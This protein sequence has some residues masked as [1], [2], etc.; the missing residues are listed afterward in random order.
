MFGPSSSKS[1]LLTTG[2]ETG[3]GPSFIDEGADASASLSTSLNPHAFVLQHFAQATGRADQDHVLVDP[4]NTTGGVH[5]GTST[6]ATA[7]T[8]SLPSLASRNLLRRQVYAA[9]DDCTAQQ[10][11]DIYEANRAEDV[12]ALSSTNDDPAPQPKDEAERSQMQAQWFQKQLQCESYAGGNK[13]RMSTSTTSYDLERRTWLQTLVFMFL[14]FY[15]FIRF[16]FVFFPALAVGMV[17]AALVGISCRVLVN[18]VLRHVFKISEH[19]MPNVKFLAP[20]LGEALASAIGCE[21]VVEGLEHLAE[22]RG[23]N[24]PSTTT[25]TAKQ[26]IA[27]FSHASGVDPFVVMQVLAPHCVFLWTFKAEL[28]FLPGPFFMAYGVSCEAGVMNRGNRAQAIKT[29]SRLAASPLPPMCAPEGTR[30]KSG[31]ILP[32]LKKGMFHVRTERQADILP[33]Y[34]NGNFE[35]WPP[36]SIVPTFGRVVVQVLPVLSV[37]AEEDLDTTRTKVRKVFLRAAA[38]RA[39]LA[40]NSMSLRF[41]LR[42]FFVWLPFWLVS[43]FVTWKMLEQMF[44]Q[45]YWCFIHY[46]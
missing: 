9:L 20:L 34:L 25:T 40:T 32:E 5:Q 1:H 17:P 19:D 2:S 44:E 21:A 18:P 27:M 41:L 14:R 42:H 16:F 3:Q 7:T 35:V 4:T 28:M 46:L 30:T 33:I 31:L 13:G 43:F 36:T 15:D 22:V 8:T 11:R 38:R 10:Q 29:C 45:G 24:S 39:E 6:S 23:P 26:Y 37:S 12:A